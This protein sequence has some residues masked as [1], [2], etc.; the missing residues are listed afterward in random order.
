MVQDGEI[1]KW[2]NCI[3]TYESVIT[4]PTC[5]DEGYTTHTCTVC[6][7]SYVTD[8]VEPEGH[9]FMITESGPDCLNT[10]GGIIV[11]TC[12][13]CGDVETQQLTWTGHVYEAT[14]IPPTCVSDGY[15]IYQCIGCVEWYYGD[16]I[17]PL[18]HVYDDARDTDCNACGHV[19]EVADVILGDAN[20]D[21]KVN[22]RDLGILQQYL[23]DWN[24][25]IAS[26]AAD[27]NGD[28]KVNNR[29]LGMLQKELNS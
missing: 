26:D 8:Y 21:G 29:D 22:N 6:G 24:V 2:A 10:I 12:L 14:V 16:V 27:L 18:D 9:D 19:R 17:P 5:V 3:H 4:P 25:T 11:K 13:R 20:G 23:N 28:G 1:E 15:T 7:D